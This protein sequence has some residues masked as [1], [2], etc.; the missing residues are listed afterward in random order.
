M[1]TT[2][3]FSALLHLEG[4]LRTPLAAS[5]VDSQEQ[6]RKHQARRKQSST[7][8]SLETREW[9]QYSYEH[10]E[11]ALGFAVGTQENLCSIPASNQSAM[12]SCQLS[13]F[14]M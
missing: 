13:L 14:Q 6:S 3:Y 10:L 8:T 9:E 5:F 4:L 11:H 2:T 7:H 1:R 12:C